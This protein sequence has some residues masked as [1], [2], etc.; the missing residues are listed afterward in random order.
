MCCGR[1][2]TS[3]PRSREISLPRMT[4]PVSTLR[5]N[6]RIATSV[7]LAI[8]RRLSSKSHVVHLAILHL[9]GTIL[10]YP[11]VIASIE[12]AEGLVNVVKSTIDPVRPGDT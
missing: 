5:P 1:I 9:P 10:Q 7:L 6:H 4:F 8:I 2:D 11:D 3:S 12:D